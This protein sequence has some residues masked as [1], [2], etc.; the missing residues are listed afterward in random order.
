VTPESAR[1]TEP[2]RRHLREMLNDRGHTRYWRPANTG[3]ARCAH[4]LQKLGLLSGS[5][6]TYNDAYFLTECGIAVA[7]ELKR[8]S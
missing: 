8:D 4:A 6:I 1:L 2:Q 3:E 7:Q 5:S